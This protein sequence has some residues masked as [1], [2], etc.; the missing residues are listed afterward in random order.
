MLTRLFGNNIH[1]YLH[2]LGLA[3]LAFG[4]P[5]NKVVMSI[6]M[7]FIVLNLLLEANFITYWKNLKSNKLLWLVVAFYLL[8]A[9]GMLWSTDLNYALFDLKAKLPLLVIPIVVVAKPLTSRQELHGILSFF[10]ASTVL[11]S[12]INFAL[13]QHWIGGFEYDDI[14]G[15]SLFS[16]HI[17]FSIIVSMTAGVCLYLLKPCS[18]LR[19]ILILLVL[20]LSYYTYYSQVL[21]G[22]STLIGVF[23]IFAIYLFWGNRRK[24][25]I[26]LMLA[27]LASVIGV[28]S[29]L[30]VPIQTDLTPLNELPKYTAEGNEYYHSNDVISPETGKPIYLYLCEDELEREWPKRSDI[31][32]QGEDYKGQPIRFTLLRYMASK[33]LRKDAE[34]LAQLTDEE[35]NSIENGVGTSK[36]YG[37]LGR[38]YG[39]KYELINEQNPNGNSL[40]ERFEFWSTACTIFTE[41]AIIGVGTGDVQL[42][43]DDVYRRGTPL[44]ESNRKRGHNMFLTIMVTF[45]VPG[46][47]LFGWMLFQYI[48]VNLKREELLA[49]I[50]MGVAIIS[51]LMED[52]LETQTGVTFFAL[53]FALFSIQYSSAESDA[54][55]TEKED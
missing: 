51:F 33:D 5:M 49:L 30:F 24:L 2:L 11:V 36:N 26:G 48:Y 40:L 29:W 17:R 20:W 7:M 19:P 32:Y 18:K 27:G 21:S 55:T 52:T 6:S 1:N 44:E 50:F 28:L 22:F 35:I 45:G 4:V 14:R 10:V 53:F 38:L 34:G 23:I 54:L 9:I 37:V 8:H 46:I 25:A 39:I 42:A 12:L 43:F 3:G 47:L 15:M 41:N 31:D 13:Y 16:S